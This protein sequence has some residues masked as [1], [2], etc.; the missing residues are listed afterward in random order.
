[1]LKLQG[2]ELGL[3]ERLGEGEHDVPRPWLA[4]LHWTPSTGARL[5]LLHSIPSAW[6]FPINYLLLMIPWATQMS[7]AKLGIVLKSSRSIYPC[8]LPI[9]TIQFRAFKSILLKTPQT[10]LS[11][12]LNLVQIHF[13]PLV[14]GE[15]PYLSVGLQTQNSLHPLPWD[16]TPHSSF[17]VLFLT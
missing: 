11:P 9:S 16:T 8:S 15:Y 14:I 7:Q 12:L 17:Q 3:L 10:H 2:E 6:L 13:S 5:S 4:C 1:M